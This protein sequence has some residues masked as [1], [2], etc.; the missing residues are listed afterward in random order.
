VRVHHSYL[1][2]DLGEAEAAGPPR[3]L[4]PTPKKPSDPIAHVP[5]NGLIGFPGQTETEVLS[6]PGQQPVEPIPQLGPGRRVAPGLAARG[7]RS[8]FRH[9]SGRS[10]VA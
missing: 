3:Q 2:I 8:D 1:A 10:G 9:L 7:R 4:M 5:V 6:P